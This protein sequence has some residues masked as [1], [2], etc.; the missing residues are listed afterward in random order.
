MAYKVLSLLLQFERFNAHNDDTGQ[1][2]SEHRNSD[3]NRSINRGEDLC[4][5]LPNETCAELNS[6]VECR[7]D[8]LKVRGDVILIGNVGINVN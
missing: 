1:E 3:D 4:R 6:Y 7:A 8:L 5:S 2:L